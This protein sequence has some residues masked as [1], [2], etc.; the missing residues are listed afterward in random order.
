MD[1]DLIWIQ[2]MKKGNRVAFSKLMRQYQNYVFTICFRVLKSQEEAEEAAQDTFI[3]VFKTIDSFK[4]ESKFSTWL[5]SI[6]F[7]T[8][9][10]HSRKKKMNVYSM[11]QEESYLQIKDDKI[12]PSQYT[13][14]HDLKKVLGEVIQ[15]LSPVD[16]NIITL[17]YQGEKSVKEI[18]E[19][20]ELTE[21][22]V[23]VKL[24]RLRETLKNKL[25]RYL[26]E[27]IK[28]LL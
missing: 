24:Y 25:T 9:I 6:A 20:L 1:R 26:R 11:D 17:Y 28:D 8:A 13:E 12:T 18:A 19:I 2:Q 5:Y 16:A 23:K 10:D 3:K 4:K 21:S 14:Q 15:K 22:N 27:E 7:R